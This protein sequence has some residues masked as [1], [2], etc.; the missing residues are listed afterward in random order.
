[1]L[2]L[3]DFGLCHIIPYGEKTTFAKFACGTHNYKAPEVLNVNQ[4]NKIILK[5]ITKLLEFKH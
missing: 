2:K 5:I 4:Y 3:A 1:M